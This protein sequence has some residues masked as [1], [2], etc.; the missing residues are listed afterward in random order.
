MVVRPVSSPL[1][2]DPLIAPALPGLGPEP[3][4]PFAR[5]TEPAEA[6]RE[7]FGF[8]AFRPGQREAVEAAV[9]GRDVLV[10]MP[11]GVGQVALLPAPGADARGPDARRLAARLADAGPGRRA[12]AGGA[13]QGRARQ[14]PAGRGRQP[15]GAGPRGV[16][17]RAAALRRARALLLARVPRAD[18]AGEGRPVRGRRGALRLAVGARLPP[19]LLPARRRRALARRARRSSPRP[20]PRRRRS[21]TT[22]SPGSGCASRCGSRPASTARTCR[23]PSC[24][25]RRRRPA[26]AASPPRSPSR[27]RCRRSSTRARG[28]SATSSPSAL[29]RRARHDVLAYHAGLPRE[30]RAEAQ[31]RFMDGEVDVVVATNA[32]GMGVDKADVRTVCHES[33]PGSIEAYYQEAGRAGRDGAAGALPAVRVRAR[34][35]PARVLHRAL[36]RRGAGAQGGGARADGRGGGVRRAGG[37]RQPGDAVRRARRAAGALRGLRRGGRPRD[38]RPSRARRRRPAERRRRPTACSAGSPAPGTAARSRCA[39]PPRRRARARAGA[40]TA[41]CGRGSRDR[42]AAARA[43]CATSATARR[44]RPT[45]RAATSATRRSLRRRPPRGPRG[46]GGPRQLAQRPVAPGDAG[47]LDEAIVEVVAAR[48]P[49]AGPHPGGRG[50]ARRSLQ[51]AAQA[52]LGRPA[53]LRH[54]RPPQRPGGARARRRAARR[55]HAQVER[56]PLPGAGG[57]REAS[58]SSPPARARTCRRSSTASTAARASRSSPSAPTS[59]PRRA[60]GAGARGGRAG[61]RVP[62]RRTSPTARARDVA[63]ADWLAGGGRGARRARRLHA[64]RRP[65]RSWRASPNA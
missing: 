33:V 17:A 48:A 45:G 52:R 14:R 40:S 59:R 21:P 64:A 43:S 49:A 58:A 50:P 6:L 47:A 23:S 44:R 22:S 63:M 54:V 34:Q 12:R 5:A 19:G 65:R 27:A 13:G 3:P 8:P 7:V 53:A 2:T 35:G 56:R 61:A 57:R 24:R 30:A 20:R 29:A 26:T 51:G 28:R 41:P 32:F 55:R 10:V 15:R 39:G 42:R 36:D 62:A 4:R 11:T 18:P 25:A 31:R 16:G 38:R 37:R 1:V 9:A 46:G 60:L